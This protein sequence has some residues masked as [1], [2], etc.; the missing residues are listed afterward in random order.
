MN[1]KV[2][3]QIVVKT[4][5]DTRKRTVVFGAVNSENG[6]LNEYLQV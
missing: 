4:N 2:G 6:E 5:G 3:T 1:A